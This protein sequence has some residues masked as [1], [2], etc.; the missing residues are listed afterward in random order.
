[1]VGNSLRSLMTK[2]RVLFDTYK[3]LLE[4]ASE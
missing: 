3:A 2:L 4:A 1:M